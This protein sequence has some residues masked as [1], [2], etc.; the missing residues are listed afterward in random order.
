MQL[1]LKTH[2]ETFCTTSRVVAD[3]DVIKPSDRLRIQRIY[4]WVE[5]TQRSLPARKTGIVEQ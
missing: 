1:H 2:I 4:Q 5:E 3:G